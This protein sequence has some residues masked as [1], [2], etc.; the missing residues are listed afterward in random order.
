MDT[1]VHI[2]KNKFMDKDKKT[3]LKQGSA[4]TDLKWVLFFLAILWFIWFFTGG[5]NRYESKKGIYIKPS[6]PVNTGEVYGP[7]F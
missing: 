3:P 2:I 7:K 4:K 1:F 6:D 5:P